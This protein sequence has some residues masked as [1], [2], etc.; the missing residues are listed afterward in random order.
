M[1]VPDMSFRYMEGMKV[2]LHAFSILAMGGS[3]S[4]ASEG[5]VPHYPLDRRLGVSK[6]LCWT[7]RCGKK[8]PPLVEL[9]TILSTA[10]HF[11]D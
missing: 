1:A 4:S 11:T 2:M 3:G 9:N 6:S 5:K 7:K 10:S 8:I